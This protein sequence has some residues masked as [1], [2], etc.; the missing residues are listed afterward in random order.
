[1][2]RIT[3]PLCTANRVFP[4]YDD[5]WRDYFRCV[6][7]QLTFVPPAF[8]LSPSDEKAVYDLH[9][10]SSA[11]QGYR[12][13]LSRIFEPVHARIAPGSH[14]LDFGSGPGPTLSVMFEEVGHHMAIYDPYYATET[15]PLAL[16][17]DFV[18]ASEVVEHLYNPG[19][20]LRR[21]WSCIK[22]GG[23]LGIMTKLALD[24]EAFARWHYKNDR[25]HVS[26]FSRETF[27][28]LAAEWNAEL[29]FVGNDVILLRHR[30]CYTSV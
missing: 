6:A 26:F 24:R 21:L 15:S 8:H 13:F 3:C 16:Q 2:S 12:N 17:Y 19:D 18:T 25:T 23:L 22:P 1:M 27:A 14:G 10:N 4:L 7:C 20:E 30:A 11:D 28:W 9:Q 29:A 5:K